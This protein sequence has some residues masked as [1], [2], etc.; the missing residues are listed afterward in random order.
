[1]DTNARTLSKTFTYRLATFLFTYWITLFFTSEQ[2]TSTIFAILSLTI[3]AISFFVHERVWTRFKWLR[4]NGDEHK[5]RSVVKTIT[6][7]LWSL[8]IVYIIGLVFGLTSNQALTL[9]LLLNIMYLLT[10]YTNERLWNLVKW[11]KSDISSAW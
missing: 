5:L 7:R 3:G 2:T 6:Y 10:H 4:T 11:G 9:T 1:M 8:L